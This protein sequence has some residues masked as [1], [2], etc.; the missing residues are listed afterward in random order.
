[1]KIPVG[2]AFLALVF[3]TILLSGCAPTSTPVTIDTSTNLN[4]EW[5]VTS[6]D[7]NEITNDIGIFEW[8]LAEELPGDNRICRTFYG[9]S[10]SASPNEAMNCINKLYPGSTFDDVI[11]SMYDSGILLSTDIELEPFLN[12][13]YDFALYTHMAD[14][15]HSFYDAFL[16]NN[17]LLFRASVGMGT[18]IGN[19]PEM[20]FS[21]QGEVI[22]AFLKSMLMTNLDRVGK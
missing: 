13:D 11:A 14:N 10:W 5:L 8:K 17:D 9:T 2:S 1:M 7:I 21:E 22:E 4:L 20:I 19:T 6:K 15:G 18:P 3:L 12:Y 16:I